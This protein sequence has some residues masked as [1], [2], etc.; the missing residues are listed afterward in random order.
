MATVGHFHKHPQLGVFDGDISQYKPRSAEEIRAIRGPESNLWRR[1]PHAVINTTKAKPVSGVSTKRRVVKKTSKTQVPGTQ[2]RGNEALSLNNPSIMTKEEIKSK[3]IK[4]D[5]QH[6]YT[7]GYVT[8]V[9]VMEDDKAPKGSRTIEFD[10]E[11]NMPMC[12]CTTESYHQD[13][14]ASIFFMIPGVNLIWMFIDSEI[15]PPSW[16]QVCRMLDTFAIVAALCLALTCTFLSAI[17]F[18]EMRAANARYSLSSFNIDSDTWDTD[19]VFTVGP[20]EV[21]NYAGLNDIANFMIASNMPHTFESSTSG[22]SITPVNNPWSV[23]GPFDDPLNPTCSN[24]TG[25]T[26]DCLYNITCASPCIYDRYVSAY[27]TIDSKYYSMWQYGEKD[28]S[29]IPLSSQ[30]SRDCNISTGFLVTS[31]FLAITVLALGSPNIFFRDGNSKLNGYFRGANEITES[32]QYRTVTKA[33]FYWIR[34][35]IMII[36]SFA[37]IGIIFFFQASKYLTY[38]KY[39]DYYV[40]QNRG[41]FILG[42]SPPPDAPYSQAQSYLLAWFWIPVVIALVLLSFGHRAAYLYPINSRTTMSDPQNQVKRLALRMD[43]IKFLHYECNVYSH[44]FQEELK[45]PEKGSQD[46]K[47]EVIAKPRDMSKFG[48]RES[49]RDFWRE[50]NH[51]V[52]ELR[53]GVYGAG[54]GGVSA[55]EAEVVADVLIDNAISLPEDVVDLYVQGIQ[56]ILYE[57]PG[58]HYSVAG[59]IIKACQRIIENESFRYR[60][61]TE[62][63]GKIDFRLA[64]DNEGDMYRPYIQLK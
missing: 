24:G 38:I 25:T 19:L 15:D 63:N 31:L 60:V 20:G 21:S 44:T 41:L 48:P 30:F 58:V 16:A 9:D 35:V 34:Y 39:P 23:V 55:T 43:M 62:S 14:F 3:N 36:V 37:L 1:H 45:F 8:Y 56:G 13:N 6:E 51:V 54:A 33:Y 26:A 49:V 28:K 10:L 59:L 42:F 12:G 32:H 27:K 61:F 2:G 17:D 4:D 57:L 18:E 22:E 64:G 11:L 46:S 47:V 5:F 53:R 40:T 29:E 52:A 50:P 7:S